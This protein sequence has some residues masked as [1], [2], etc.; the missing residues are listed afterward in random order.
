MASCSDEDRDT[1]TPSFTFDMNEAIIIV[2][3]LFLSCF[4][5]VGPNYF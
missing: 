3:L 1:P 4:M 5:Y 2:H